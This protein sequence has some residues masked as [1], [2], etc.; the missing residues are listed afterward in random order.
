VTV[1][2]PTAVHQA[3]TVRFTASVANGSAKRYYFWWFAA[4]CA[5]SAGCAPSSYLPMADGEGK[6]E[7]SLSFGAELRE[8]DL[9]VQVAEI[10]GRGRTGSSP[11]FI[12]DGPARHVGSSGGDAAFSGVCD[13][14]A[15]SFYP[16]SGRYTDPFSGRTWE[17]SFR[18]DYCGN[19]MSWDPAG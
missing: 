17:R 6:D 3:S 16:H 1:H 10:D 7:V 18:R 9:V 14:F 4:A 5:N 13:W 15:G 19:R 2:G 12:V 11:E 8:R